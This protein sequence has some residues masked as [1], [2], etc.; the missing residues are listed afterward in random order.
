MTGYKTYRHEINPK[1][2]Q[3]HDNFLKDFNREGYYDM[4]LIVF[5]HSAQ[6]LAPNDCLSD[7]EKRIVLSTIQWLGSCGGQTF[8]RDCGFEAI[9]S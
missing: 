8:L 2:K 7:R 5:G 3:F 6:S 4:D 9:E 1:E